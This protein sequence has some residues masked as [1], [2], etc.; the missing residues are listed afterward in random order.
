M[1]TPSTTQ[2]DVPL[3]NVPFVDKVTG[4]VTEAWFLFLIQLWR[5]TG[6]GSGIS[7]TQLTVGDVLAL[8]ETFASVAP[9]IGLDALVGESTFG[10]IGR[11][12]AL[13]EMVFAPLSATSGGNGIVADQTFSS[14]SDF[15]PGVSTTLTL[16]NSFANASQLWIFFDG[17]FQ[18]DD[19]YSLSGAVVTFTSAIPVG[20]SKVYIKGVR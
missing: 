1:S 17:A 19:Q 5:R 7:P 18:G 9:V 14:G 20:V 4:N 12:D 8:E 15:T 11:K 10:M 13:T 3:V 16:D 6:G 2:T